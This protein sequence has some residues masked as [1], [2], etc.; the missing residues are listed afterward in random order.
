M[1]TT[2]SSNV[3]ICVRNKQTSEGTVPSLVC[4][5]M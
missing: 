3:I 5:S 4:F 1:E 2:L